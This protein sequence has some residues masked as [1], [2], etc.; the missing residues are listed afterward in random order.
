MLDAIGDGLLTAGGVRD[1]AVA[2]GRGA[3]RMGG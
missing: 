2:R 3:E 1:E